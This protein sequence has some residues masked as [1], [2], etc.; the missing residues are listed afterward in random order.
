M[1]FAVLVR[2]GVEKETV[3]ALQL[4]FFGRRRCCSCCSLEF[5]TLLLEPLADSPSRSVTRQSRRLL[6]HFTF[7]LCEVLRIRSC[8]LVGVVQFWTRLSTC[9]SLCTA[10]TQWLM[11]LL[12]SALAAADTVQLCTFPDKVDKVLTCPFLCRF[13]DGR[14]HGGAQLQFIDK[15]VGISIS[16]FSKKREML[17]E[18]LK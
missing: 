1:P 13:R 5:W 11:S 12:C 4:Q 2:F 14:V 16:F 7:F 9:L 8:R 18:I 10:L 17:Q 3:E 15:V 6:D